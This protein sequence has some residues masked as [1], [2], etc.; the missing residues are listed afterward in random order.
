MSETNPTCATCPFYDAEGSCEYA[1]DADEE[2]IKGVCRV[3]PPT[4]LRSDTEGYGPKFGWPHV[5]PDDWCG[6]HPERR[7]WGS[8]RISAKMQE[9]LPQLIAALRGQNSVFID[10]AV[11]VVP[12][13]DEP[14]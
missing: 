13:E 3:N 9:Y 5:E 6:L 12:E 8:G 11:A 14:S 4:A 2:P 1:V 10:D 7:D